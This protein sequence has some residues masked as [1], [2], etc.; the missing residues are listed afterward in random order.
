M[1]AA[2]QDTRTPSKV[3]LLSQEEGLERMQRQAELLQP[4][5][6][7]PA[8]PRSSSA[9]P[10]QVLATMTALLTVVGAILAARLVMLLSTLGAFVLA[11]ATIANPDPLKLGATL[12]YDICIV[13][14]LV[15]LALKKA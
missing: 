1:E 2:S 5:P 15:Y 13:G 14:P 7:A 4:Q 10:T 9:Y 8:S 3:R 6:P 12:I 11:W